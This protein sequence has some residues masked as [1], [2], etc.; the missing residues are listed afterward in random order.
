[1]DGQKRRIFLEVQKFPIHWTNIE[2][3]G[4]GDDLRGEGGLSGKYL[5]IPVLPFLKYILRTAGR[6][7]NFLEKYCGILPP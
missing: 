1:M 2:R 6:G 5:M 7:Q 3:A 4:G